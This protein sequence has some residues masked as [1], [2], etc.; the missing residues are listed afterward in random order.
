MPYVNM[1][2]I[3]QP[4]ITVQMVSTIE[5]EANM[6]AHWLGNNVNA[7]PGDEM[8]PKLANRNR[9][10]AARRRLYEDG[11]EGAQLYPL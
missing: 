10:H 8:P 4:N 11:A 2:L 6:Y 9:F 3:G 1:S 5:D 7:N